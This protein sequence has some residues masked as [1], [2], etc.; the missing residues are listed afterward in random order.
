MH[1]VK[2]GDSYTK[3]TMECK[4]SYCHDVKKVDDEKYNFC[5]SEEEWT[6]KHMEEERIVKSGY[7]KE[8]GDVVGSTV[9]LMFALFL[10]CFALYWIVRILHYLVLAS[11]RQSGE[12]DEQSKFMKITRKVLGMNPV[13]S[14]IYGALMTIAV[15]SSSIVTSTL[16]PLVALGI[17]TLEEVLPLTLGANIGTTVTA[18]IA[19]VVSGSQDAIQVSVCHLLFNLLGIA[20]W[21]PI[22]QMRAVPLAWARLMGEYVL[23]FPWFGAFYIGVSFVALPLAL[24]L[25]SLLLVFGTAGLIA[26]IVLSLLVVVGTVY[27]IFNFK[28]VTGLKGNATP[29]VPDASKVG[30]PDVESQER[31]YSGPMTL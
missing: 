7:A 19:S 10:L 23:E 15:Q 31:E 2:D 5:I 8:L 30:K 11:G 26:N 29:S 25:C 22:P 18:F 3:G 13:L 21:Y 24:Y 27:F 1:D 28:K 12:G 9:V 20:I 6:R 17:I 16:T 4:D 14:I